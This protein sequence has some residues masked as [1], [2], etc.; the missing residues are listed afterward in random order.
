[1]MLLYII[2]KAFYKEGNYIIKNSR[3]LSTRLPKFLL[4]RAEAYRKGKAVEDY[5]EGSNRIDT[6]VIVVNNKVET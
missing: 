3:D 5:I 2:V 4:H 6:I 1:M